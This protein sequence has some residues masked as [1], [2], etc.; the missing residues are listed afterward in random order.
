MQSIAKSY[1]EALADL[2][3]DYRHAHGNRPASAMEVAKWAK[4]AGKW[5][6][7]KRDPVR[8]FAHQLSKAANAQRYHDEHGRVVKAMQPA[9]YKRMLA[10]GQMIIDAVWDHIATMSDDHARVSFTQQHAQWV[11]HGRSIKNS[12][13]SFYDVNPNAGERIQLTFNLELL[14]DQ[15]EEKIVDEIP[16][17]RVA[18]KKKPK[19]K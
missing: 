5:I 18:G 10:G 6:P 19:P 14:I 1:S 12:M 3:D 13:D 9:K 2:W 17:L 7:K 11:G 16:V 4:E 8:E 15:P